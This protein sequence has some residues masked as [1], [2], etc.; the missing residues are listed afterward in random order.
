M[1]KTWS[2]YD[3]KTKEI[4]NFFED[5]IH[6]VNLYKKDKGDVQLSLFF[7]HLIV[8]NRLQIDEINKHFT[9]DLKN[10]LKHILPEVGIIF[11]LI[12]HVN[13]SNNAKKLKLT[14]QGVEFIFSCD[15]RVYISDGFQYLY[16]NCKF[17]ITHDSQLRI[18]SC[19]PGTDTIGMTNDYTTNEY[20]VTT[21]PK[22]GV[23]QLRNHGPPITMIDILY[24]RSREFIPKMFLPDMDKIQRSIFP[25]SYT[26]KN[27]VYGYT[28]MN[29]RN[30]CWLSAILWTLSVTPGILEELKLIKS[31]LS[32]LLIQTITAHNFP[33]A[34]REIS[35]EQLNLYIVGDRRDPEYSKQQCTA[36][37]MTQ[38]I[39]E[40][41]LSRTFKLDVERVTMMST[42]GSIQP[43]TKYNIPLQFN[44]TNII[45]STTI[46]FTH[47]VRINYLPMMVDFVQPSSPMSKS[48]HP[49]N[50]VGKTPSSQT[51]NVTSRSICFWLF[52]FDQNG[53]KI[54]QHVD[55][56][57]VI[58]LNDDA[59]GG[60]FK[61]T[62]VDRVY[63]LYSIIVHVGESTSSGH[64][65]AYVHNNSKWYYC[66]DQRDRIE[67]IDEY[68]VKEGIKQAYLVFYTKVDRKQIFFGKN[69]ITPI[70][71]ISREIIP[72]SVN[73]SMY[74]KFVK[75]V[76]STVSV[77]L[78]FFYSNVGRSTPPLK[79]INITD[80]NNT[81]I[82]NIWMLV[83]LIGSS[84]DCVN[85]DDQHYYFGIKK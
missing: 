40:L 14:N 61:Y 43:T 31:Q 25:T 7:E 36:H 11:E 32:T 23:I 66:D 69:T 46:P 39:S 55:I 82:E 28:F 34:D 81:K 41:G 33:N 59:F 75:L 78:D 35:T 12:S 50:S 1:I 77:S 56:P 38:M 5:L 60:T 85:E 19:D 47:L 27:K 64:Y 22:S 30:T 58:D 71:D 15:S 65:I 52:R 6:V 26:D 51:L 68:K 49:P 48:R 67:S 45:N 73:L 44:D 13:F 70:S 18:K 74:S 2:Y 24:L 8:F 53:N 84:F 37:R 57:F 63:K 62:D 10:K 76:K 83:E 4:V 42:G 9:D 20:T 80:P 3:N 79:V 54:N 21:P 17:K 29:N 16:S 72:K